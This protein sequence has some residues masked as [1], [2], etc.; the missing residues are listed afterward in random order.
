MGGTAKRIEMTIASIDI[1]TNTVL[2]LIACVD[3]AGAITPIVYDQRIPRLGKGVDATRTLQPEA[4]QRVVDVLLE[5]R[6]MCQAHHADRVIVCGTSALRDAQN[7][8]E[9]A[10]LIRSATGFTLEVLSGEEEAYWTY[11][12]AV[13]GVPGVHRA[14]VVDIGGGSTEI[15]IGTKEAILRAVSLDIGSVR[16]TERHFLHDPPTEAELAMAIAHVKD[17]LLRVDADDL[18]GTTA[19]GVAGTVTSLAILAQERKEFSIEA[20]TNYHLSKEQVHRLFHRL[21]T[22]PSAKIRELSAVLEGRSDVIL[23]GTLILRELMEHCSFQEIIVSERGVRYGLVLREW[24]RQQKER[25][26]GSV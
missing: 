6:A 17:E 2:L 24:E 8:E 13:S 1:G 21:Q 25:S 18:A 10:T 12:G 20:V 11:R 16:L 19:I 3:D 5:Y 15:T 7:R 22:M 14:T 23:A 9:F 26:K 4:M